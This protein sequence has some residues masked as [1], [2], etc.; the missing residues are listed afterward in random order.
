MSYGVPGAYTPYPV[1]VMPTAPMPPAPMTVAPPLPATPAPLGALPALLPQDRWIPQAPPVAPAFPSPVYPPAPW[2]SSPL[3]VSEPVIVNPVV[4]EPVV[5]EPLVPAPVVPDVSTPEPVLPIPEPLPPAPPVAQPAVPSPPPAPPSYQ[6]KKVAPR[7]VR[8]AFKRLDKND[9]EKLSRDEFKQ[10]KGESFKAHD[11]NHDRKVT[12]REFLLR[13]RKEASFVHLDRND[14]GKLTEK[15]ISRIETP[16]GARFDGNGD[17]K[18]TR[19]EFLKG[20]KADHRAVSQ[21]KNGHSNERQRR[22][23]IF[24][25]ADENRDGTL[26]KGELGR[27]KSYDRNHN[28]MISKNEFKAARKADLEQAEKKLDL[29]GKLPE[30][31]SKRLYMDRL[32]QAKRVPKPGIYLDPDKVAALLGSPVEN[33]RQSLPEI[34]KAIQEAGIKDRNTIIAIL[35][36]IRTE[37]GSF[38]PIHEY[39]GPSYWAQYNG[40]TDLGNVRPGDGVRYHGRGYIQLTGRHNYRTYGDA[41]GVDLEAKPNKALNPKV[42]AQ[43]LI[44]YFKSHGIPQMARQ[45]AW[46]SV[47][48]AVNG[49]DNGWETFQW[50]VQRLKSSSSWLKA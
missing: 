15:E 2:P 17:G 10:A 34:V 47:R 30:G 20:R 16:S 21:G 46:Y 25:L 27:Y 19:S 12:W 40:R 11:L 49:G 42:A 14:D 50:A 36:T 18:V 7:T 37:V 22:D 33:V 38:L 23:R 44:A 28:G 43:V 48:R 29:E 32:G 4:L 13:Q 26:R 41:V 5:T 45:G 9:S 8:G 6:P 1:P 35:A 24:A 3:P 31:L 39:G